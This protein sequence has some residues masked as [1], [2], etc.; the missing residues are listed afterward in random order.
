MTKRL[1]E[2]TAN[3]ISWQIGISFFGAPISSEARYR[4]KFVGHLLTVLGAQNPSSWSHKKQEAPKPASSRLV[5]RTNWKSLPP[6][7]LQHLGSDTAVSSSL[8]D[9]IKIDLLQHLQRTC[10]TVPPSLSEHVSQRLQK[11]LVNE[12][13]YP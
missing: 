11:R 9:Q 2:I 6:S 5:L 3:Q 10:S 12:I 13:S 4:K 7:Q 8:M 1:G